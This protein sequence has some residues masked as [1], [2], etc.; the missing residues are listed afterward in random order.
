MMPRISNVTFEQQHNTATSTLKVS[1]DSNVPTTSTVLTYEGNSTSATETSLSSLST[2]HSILISDLKDNTI[3]RMVVEG[4]DAYGNLAVSDTNRVTT[5]YD[6]RPPDVSN[7]ITEST[8][9]GYGA[10]TVAQVIVSWDTDELATSQ[11]EYSE[12]ITGDSYSMSTVKDSSLTTSHV[13]VLRDLKPS[14]SYYFRVVTADASANTTR[15]D[16]GSAL[17]GFIQSSVLDT[18]LK[19]LQ[20][21]FGWL[22]K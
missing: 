20:G 17:T 3:Y 12:G 14:S 13:V 18:V 5:A 15:S 7:I 6:T 21:A 9:S 8:I 22:F 2:K 16:P 10:D 4:R 19:S 1:W 11:V